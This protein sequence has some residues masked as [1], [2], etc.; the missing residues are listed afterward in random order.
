MMQSRYQRAQTYLLEEEVVA[1][2]WW[3]IRNRTGSASALVSTTSSSARE[4]GMTAGAG[5][6]SGEPGASASDAAGGPD[7]LTT[8]WRGMATP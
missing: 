5:P 2:M 4:I 3:K 7:V 6:H 8:L 1:A